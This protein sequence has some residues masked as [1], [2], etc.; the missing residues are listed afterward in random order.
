M[1]QKIKIKELNKN[2]KKKKK[3]Q[4]NETKI[5]KKLETVISN[6][7]KTIMKKEETKNILKYQLF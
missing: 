4:R 6:Q 7:N 5:M 3:K 1:S 2:M